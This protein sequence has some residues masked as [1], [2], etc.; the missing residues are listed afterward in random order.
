MQFH[1]DELLSLTKQL[2]SK[3]C[4]C[5]GS[6]S[7]LLVLG[8]GDIDENFGGRVINM[9]RSEDGGSVICNINMLILGASCDR[10]KDFIHS[11]W[12]EGGFDQIGHC[13]GSNE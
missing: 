8:L 4:D 13:N 12:A 2:S 10:H 6:I 11:S 3:Y 7:N 9:H 1:V 5:G